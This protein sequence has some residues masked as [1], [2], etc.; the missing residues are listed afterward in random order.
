[1][2]V[3]SVM[4][5]GEWEVYVSGPRTHLLPHTSFPLSMPPP[6]ASSPLVRQTLNLASMHYRE[7]SHFALPA[8]YL[9]IFSSQL[10]NLNFQTHEPS[11]FPPVF[12]TC[13]LT[14]PPM[15]WPQKELDGGISE[16]KGR[17]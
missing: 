2:S 14:R 4:I 17:H 11:P 5:M 3:L 6:S 7:P 1:M 13:H 8:P 10:E 16:V 12:I 9:P 15:A